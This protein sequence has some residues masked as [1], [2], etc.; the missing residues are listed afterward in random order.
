[1]ILIVTATK[2]LFN[3][4]SMIDNPKEILNRIS[5]SLKELG[6]RNMYMAMLL[7]KI[8]KEKM[9]ISS[10]GIPFTYFYQKKEKT[11]KEIKLKGMPLGSFPGFNYNSKTINLVKGDTF[12]F[13]SDGLSECFNNQ[14][15]IIGESRIKSFV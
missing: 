4:F 5:F 13:H 15:K 7:T 12:L 11:V 10:A 8:S 14:N 3:S 9:T 6:F 1:M 2:V